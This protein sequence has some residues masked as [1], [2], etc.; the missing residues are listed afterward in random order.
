M[1]AGVRPEQNCAKCGACSTVCPVYRQTG[2]EYHTGRGKLHLLSRLDPTA[3]STVYAEILS[4][5]LLC[6]ACSQVCSRRLPVAE[7]L[8]EARGELTRRAGQHAMLRA[9]SNGLLSR[10][11]LLQALAPLARRLK[12]L[13][14]PADSGLN[15]R[16]GILPDHQPAATSEPPRPPEKTAPATSEPYIFSGCFAT[17]L[18]PEITRALSNLLTRAGQPPAAPHPARGCC[19]LAA[20]SCGQKEEARRMARVNIAAHPGQSPI[21]VACASCASHLLRYPELL[22]DDPQWAGR[23]ED[24]AARVREFSHFLYQQPPQPPPTPASGESE[25]PADAAAGSP[26][27]LKVLYHDP[28]HLRFGCQITREPRQLLN[29]LPGLELLE[30]P[31]GPQCC[32]HGGHFHLAHPESA[33]GILRR[34][35]EA[36]QTVAPEVITTACTGCLLHWRHAARQGY[37]QARV[38]H[39]AVLL[40]KL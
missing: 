19:G 16:L 4:H 14:L 9:L 21:V 5:C 33:E 27:T 40:D 35:S 13:N 26:K 3:A 28:C 8:A 31:D 24:F 6:G 2:R 39:L 20:Y 10:P 29:R 1:S 34:L 22:A 30:L 17:Y 12:E 25:G 32:G 36:A 37:H 15:L 23:A 38:I 11:R 18:E 7:M